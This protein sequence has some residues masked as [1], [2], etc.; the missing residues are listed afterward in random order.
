MSPDEFGDPVWRREYRRR[1]GV[2]FDGISRGGAHVV[3]IGL[4][5][6]RNPKQSARFEVINAAVVAE[7]AGAAPPGDVRR[8]VHDVRRPERRLRRVPGNDP[9]AQSSRCARLTASTS[10][11]PA[12]R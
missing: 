4:P 2:L 8:H 3:W 11:G 5:L 1:L 10:R 6:T 9:P 7:A 12:A